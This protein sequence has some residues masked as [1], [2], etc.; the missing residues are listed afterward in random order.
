MKYVVTLVYTRTNSLK[1]YL[2]AHR[3]HQYNI[4][5]K[6]YNLQKTFK[7]LAF[8]SLFDIE[9]HHRFNSTFVP[10]R[11]LYSVK[12]KNVEQ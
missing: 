5:T 6:R 8:V 10:V 1:I 2:R 9:S 7:S 4:L 11:Q 12:N 3:I